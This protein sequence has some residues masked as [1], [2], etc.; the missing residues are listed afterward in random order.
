MALQRQAR[1]M[2]SE[3]ARESK[4]RNEGEEVRETRR[5]K[6]NGREAGLLNASD[7]ALATDME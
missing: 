5:E 7:G 2:I 1:K 6:R 3:R 4:R